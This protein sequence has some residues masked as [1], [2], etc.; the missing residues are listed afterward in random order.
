M[1]NDFVIDPSSE[2]LYLAD[3]SFLSLSPALIVYSV[4]RNMAYRILSGHSSLYGQS[5]FLSIPSSFSSADVVGFGP[6]GMKIHVDSIAL[7]KTGSY[8]YYGAFTGS[9]LYS[10]S[11]AALLSYVRRIE[12]LNAT[13]NDLAASAAKK[14]QDDITAELDG[15]FLSR[16]IHLVTSKKM[17]TD[18]LISD[19][20]D[21]IWMTG[22][23]HSS[24]FVGKIRIPSF[25]SHIGVSDKVE[26]EIKKV[27]SSPSLL[28]WPDG[29]S[30]DKEDGSLYI[31]CSSLHAKFLKG[32]KQV[33]DYSPFHI[34]KLP[35][36]TIEN[37]LK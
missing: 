15:L 21:R 3:T 1:L 34:L 25:S 22:V 28:R 5:T 18:G 2:Y 31:S 32:G 4:E 26:L 12:S 8:L 7:D 6:F 24:L 36:K 27:V 9:H 33:A 13:A 19:S 35:G 14:T 17:V 16:S 11:T 10:I 37:L 29:L 23:E 30:F 20:Q